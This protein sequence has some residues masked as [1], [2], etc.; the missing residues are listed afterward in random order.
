MKPIKLEM[1]AFGSYAAFTE[2]RFSELQGLYLITGDTGAGK[3]TIFDAIMFALY[4]CASGRD[5]TPEMMHSDLA[6]KS[7]DTKVRLIFLHDGKE[8]RVE[9]KIHFARI[10]GAEEQYRKG[11]LDAELTEPD[12]APTQKSDRVTARCT[13]LLGLNADQFRKIVMLAQGEFREF[14]KADSKTKGEILRELFDSTPC[15][16]LQDL[17][18]GARDQLRQQ[19]QAGTDR[20]ERLMRQEFQLPEGEKP[21]DYLPGC[22]ELA[23]HLRE[24]TERETAAWQILA[25]QTAAARTARD[26]LLTRRTEAVRINEDLDRLETY[27]KDLEALEAQAGTY[28][29]REAAEH[30]LRKA[31]HGVMPAIR[32]AQRS[33]RERDAAKT[34]L[35]Q[36]RAEEAQR[37]EAYS[38]VLAQGAEDPQRKARRDEITGLLAQADQRLGLFRDRKAALAARDAADGRLEEAKQAQ[39]LLAARQ[40]DREAARQALQAHLAP[41]ED[42]ELTAARREHEAEN[43]RLRFLRL[44]GPDGILER[45]ARLLRQQGVLAEQERRF[46]ACTA[47]VLRAEERY[48]ALYRRFIAGQAGLLADRLRSAVAEAGEGIC[49]VCGSRVRPGELNRLAPLPQDTPQ[50]AEVDRAR[51]E[52]DALERKRADGRGKLDRMTAEQ[53]AKQ[54]GLL[55]ELRQLCPEPEPLPALTDNA[56]FARLQEAFTAVD[57]RAAA[58]LREAQAVQKRKEQLKRNLTEAETALD[59]LRTQLEEAGRAVSDRAAALE[60]EESR[61]R[62]LTEQAGDRPE[63]E[64]RAE[65]QALRQEQDALARELARHEQAEKEA[66]A[67]L[68]TAAG[69]RGNAE[70]QLN[71]LEQTALAA[72]QAQ[73]AALAAQGFADAAAVERALLPARGM[74]PELWLRQEQ[75]A[76]S[77]YRHNVEARRASVLELAERTEGRTRTDL[78]ILN[79]EFQAAEE[80]CDQ[81]EQAAR[82]AELQLEGH[83]RIRREAEACLKALAQTRSAWERLSRLADLAKGAVGDGG[84]L[85]FE[86]YVMGA[87]FREVLE[88]ANRRLDVISGGRYEL[89]HRVT[90][91][92]KRVQGGLDIEVLDL[93]TG[94]QRPSASLSGGEGFY[95]S[96]ALALGMS[97][98]VQLHAGGRRLDTLF[99]DEGFGTLSD[100]MLDRAL[101]V[102]KQLS[103]G[104]R[105]IGVISHVD[106]LN[107][108]IGQKIVVK[109]GPKGSTAE[110]YS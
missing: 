90:A 27:R 24:L 93:T 63:A 99:I 30:L 6:P 34:A 84:R 2:V 39:T 61:V 46:L 11:D 60:A 16:W 88:M 28:G 72:A 44:C 15:V 97:D 66:K 19:R 43:A 105:L 4:G 73:T 35:E 31:Y 18:S 37:Q 53:A 69:R 100:D 40:A 52:F 49:P 89:I 79:A 23:A 80:A 77:D 56:G 108:S 62:L 51:D 13:E 96:L 8:Y 67:A 25:D 109:S 5:R 64:V 32:D 106:R 54:E 36:R 29:A 22:P 98:V 1:T 107:A 26:R 9:R 110:I 76:L 83:R 95:T 20:L 41:L 47:E 65:A 102:L 104:N 94:K 86:R 12:R 3:T 75:T 101:E 48:D 91:G 82:Q 81:Q 7:V 10:R 70:Q 59:A 38:Q 57:Q 103:A 50:Q 78:E 42:A 71:Q 21:D 14:L 55:A 58:A 68:D 92:D 85:S 17:L 87:M 45:R 74:D 33:A